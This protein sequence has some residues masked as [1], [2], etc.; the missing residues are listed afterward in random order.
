MKAVCLMVVAT[1]LSNCAYKLTKATPEIIDVSR[2]YA[3]IYNFKNIQNPQCGDPLYEAV[4]SGKNI[5]LKDMSGHI[6]IPTNQAQEMLRYYNEYEKKNKSCH[7]AIPEE[8]L[9]KVWQHE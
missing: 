9:E 7:H 5:D 4:Y 2:G 1:V 6:C 3:R 8:S